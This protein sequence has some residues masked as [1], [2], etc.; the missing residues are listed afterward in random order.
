MTI[1]DPE[2]PLYGIS[3]AAQLTGMHPQSIRAYEDRG[4]LSPARTDGGTRRY[5]NG[6]IGRL[7]RIGGL[8]GDGLN[9]AGIEVVLALE[10]ENQRLRA[11][12][13]ALRGAP[14]DPAG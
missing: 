4:L 3:V 9:L 2:H 6:D 13:D 14:E 8:L 1:A 12:I 11:E 10:A 7:H 5:S